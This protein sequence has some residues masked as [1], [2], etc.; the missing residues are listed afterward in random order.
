MNIKT[1]VNV[2]EV[3]FIVSSC[4][5]MKPYFKML[6]LFLLTIVLLD[7]LLLFYIYIFHYIYFLKMCLFNQKSLDFFYLNF[8]IILNN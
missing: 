6:P 8:Y 4:S 5:Q 7:V 2:V 1:L 3:S